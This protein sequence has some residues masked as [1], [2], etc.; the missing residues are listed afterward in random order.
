MASIL[1]WPQCVNNK[2]LKLRKW[3]SAKVHILTNTASQFASHIDFPITNIQ[4][5]NTDSG[6]GWLPDGTKPFSDPVL[7]EC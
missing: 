7:S 1:F 5:V 6:N 4:L 2:S 3:L